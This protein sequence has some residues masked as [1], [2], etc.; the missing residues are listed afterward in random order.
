MK[1]KTG[2]PLSLLFIWNI[3]LK[4]YAEGN[5]LWAEGNKLWAEGSKLRAEGN[6]LWAEGD[7]LYAE[8]DKLCAEG[9]KLMAEGNKLWAEAIL[10]VHGNIKLEWKPN[11]DCVLETGEVFKVKP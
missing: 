1:K 6:K 2:K 10:E 7:K 11:G 3:R 8:G 4:L 9:N 5:K